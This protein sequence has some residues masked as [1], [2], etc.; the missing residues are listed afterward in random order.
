MI[1]IVNPSNH[2]YYYLF[3]CLEED[4]E[5]AVLNMHI[6]LLLRSEDLQVVGKAGSCERRRRRC[7][8][9]KPEHTQC[10]VMARLVLLAE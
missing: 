7:V 10:Q 9:D 3:R 5:Q 6:E 8:E 1:T 2:S 4:G